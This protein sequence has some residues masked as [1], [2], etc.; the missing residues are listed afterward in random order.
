MEMI[1]RC[2]VWEDGTPTFYARVLVDSSG[3]LT[4]VT[5]AAV[6]TLTWTV[7]EVLSDGSLGTPTTG[8]LTVSSVVYDTL[9]TGTVWTTF[10]DDG[11]FKSGLIGYNFRTQLAAANFPK[12]KTTYRVVFK[13]T[14]TGGTVFFDRFD[15]TTLATS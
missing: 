7:A 4:A 11:Q 12:G 14:L 2:V 8:T 9:Q 10:V 3:T 6:S 1:H 5:Q 13:W 15:A